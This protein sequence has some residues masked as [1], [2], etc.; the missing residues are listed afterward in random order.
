MFFTEN[1]RQIIAIPIYSFIRSIFQMNENI[2]NKWNIILYYIT[3]HSKIQQM[4]RSIS[5]YFV[6]P[7]KVH[8]NSYNLIIR[9]QINVL[10][11][12]ESLNMCSK[13][14]S[15][16]SSELISKDNVLIFWTILRKPFLRKLVTFRFL[17]IFI[18]DDP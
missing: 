13:K 7:Y 9:T 8:W 1:Y 11:S 18:H 6:L 12:D 17:V 2:R 15:S 16:W 5:F 3:I 4:M 14:T 10:D